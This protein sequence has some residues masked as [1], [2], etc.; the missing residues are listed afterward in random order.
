MT[1]VGATSVYS[2]R[3]KD[4]VSRDVVWVNANDTIEEALSLMVENHVSALPV[5]N[6]R[7]VCVGI[8]SATDLVGL[9]RE[10]NEDMS[11]MR[12]TDF[13]RQWVFDRLAEQDLGRRRVSEFMT[14][15]V[16]TISP[17]ASLVSAARAMLRNH[18]H[19]LP[20]IDERRR[21][22][23]IISTSDIV[24]AFVDGAPAQF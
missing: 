9:A 23:G 11:N 7:D 15:V 13:A 2:N 14:E 22:V 5:L 4:V 8:L 6:G 12:A 1:A 20:V 18:V 17:N 24:A 21:L 10:L 19:R 3:V 16:E